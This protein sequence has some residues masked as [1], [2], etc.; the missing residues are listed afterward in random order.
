MQ[1]EQQKIEIEI[2]LLTHEITIKGGDIDDKRTK[3]DQELH[4]Q[5]DEIAKLF[6]NKHTVH[7]SKPVD[8][9]KRHMITSQSAS[10]ER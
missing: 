6:D 1:R 7:K 5:I 4:Q 8:K 3:G 2:D 10:Q 9:Q